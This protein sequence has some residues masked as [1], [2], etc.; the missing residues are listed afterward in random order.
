MILA[1][2]VGGTKVVLALFEDLKTRKKVKEQKFA[3]K[4]YA[5]FNDIVN[6]FLP[7]DISIDCACFGIAGPIVNNRCHA[8]NL[9]WVI[10]GSELQ[11]LLKTS[12]V[13]LI[14]DL[15]ANAW[16]TFVLEEHEFCI[17]NQ[18]TEKAG[19]RAL[20]S[21]GT[22]LGEAG[23][24]FDGKN[25]HPFPSE[26]GHA[27]FAPNT[28]EEIEIWRY[29]KTKFE[30]V[31]F[32][33][34]LCG[35]GIGTLYQFF[36]EVKKM[37]Q[38]PD[39]KERMQKED[40]AQVISEFGVSKKCPTC[41]KTLETFVSIYGEEAGNLALKFLSLGGIFIGGGIAPKILEV[42]KNGLFMKAFIDKGRFKTLLSEIRV[43]VILNPETALLG[44]A[45]HA[46]S[47]NSHLIM[48]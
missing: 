40:P 16:G 21:A 25:H 9:P 46:I 15:E 13:F 10:D 35:H 1:G 20:I 11:A 32:E 44:A 37:P 45:R 22:G 5:N 3:S 2:D 38:L 47:K 30:H 27:D 39:V 18:G 29:F 48:E 34:L 8:T 41:V 4:D 12:S 42:L 28:E 7:K 17:L 24:Y 23:F 43:Q 33:R 31:S 19:N 26:G 36:I 14:N 6:T